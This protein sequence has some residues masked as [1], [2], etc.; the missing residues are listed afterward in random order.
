MAV[1][2]QVKLC[3]AVCVEYKKNLPNDS[4]DFNKID[5][6]IIVISLIADISALITVTIVG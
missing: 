1:V 5:G 6:E 4:P 3:C 2:G